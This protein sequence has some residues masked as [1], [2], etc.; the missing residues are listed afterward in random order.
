MADVL[1]LLCRGGWAQWFSAAIPAVLCRNAA[2]LEA[3]GISP[4]R[5]EEAAVGSGRTFRAI[6][7]ELIAARARIRLERALHEYAFRTQSSSQACLTCN[8]LA[9]LD[10]ACN[11]LEA[12]LLAVLGDQAPN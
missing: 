1:T 7:R 10:V 6:A 3:Q 5:I 4:T 8:P 12:R 2:E 9:A 11:G